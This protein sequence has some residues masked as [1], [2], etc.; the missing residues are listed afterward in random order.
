[1]P[2]EDAVVEHYK[3]HIYDKCVLVL[4]D[5]VWFQPEKFC[6][7]LME[8]SQELN[9][10]PETAFSAILNAVTVEKQETIIDKFLDVMLLR[11]YKLNAE[12]KKLDVKE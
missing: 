2:S 1:M 4:E 6:I 10:N 7:A 12:R 5:S 3:K 11:R 9:C 8:V